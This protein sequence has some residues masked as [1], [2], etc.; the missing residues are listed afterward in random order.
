RGRPTGQSLEDGVDFRQ[1]TLAG[2]DELE[3]KIRRRVDEL[4]NHRNVD[5][6]P[7]V[8]PGETPALALPWRGVGQLGRQAREVEFDG[9]ENRRRGFDGDVM[10]GRLERVA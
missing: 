6:L 9:L 8:R 4:L 3:L 2:D 5:P 10:T 1:V 7:L